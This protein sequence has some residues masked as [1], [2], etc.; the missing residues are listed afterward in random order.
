MQTLK[1]TVIQQLI[2]AGIN[3]PVVTACIHD[4]Y[5][6]YQC[7]SMINEP[8]DQI[9][10]FAEKH[11]FEVAGRGYLNSRISVNDITSFLNL[12]ASTSKLG[13]EPVFANKNLVIDFSSPNIAKP[14]HAGH[15]RSTFIG[16][17][18]AR[19]AKEV[20]YNVHCVNHLGDCGAQFGKLLLG[21]EKTDLSLLSLESMADAYKSVTAQIA[22]ENLTGE[23]YTNIAARNTLTKLHHGDPVLTNLWQQCQNISLSN[24]KSVYSDLGIHFDEF[25]GESTYLPFLPALVKELE[26]NG[27][28]TISNGAKIVEINNLP[29]CLIQKQDGAFLYATTDLA[30]LKHRIDNGADEIWYVVGEPQ[31]LHLK[32][33]FAVSAVSNIAKHIDFGSILGTDGKIMKSRSGD[34]VLLQDILDQAIAE[35]LLIINSKSS[36]GK[37]SGNKD[38]VAK[39]IGYGAIKFF[40]LSQNRSSNYKF[41][42]KIALSLKSGS[43]YIQ[44]ACCRIQSILN[45]KAVFS[46]ILPEET[47]E[48][49]KL[50]LLLA[51]FPE[52]IEDVT[53]DHRIHFLPEY[54]KKTAA[55]FHAFYH[56]HTISGKFN[57]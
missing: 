38:F 53:Q 55:A 45:G 7:E 20:G 21:L 51:R 39:Q 42:L 26:E 37:M 41:D 35:A 52:V 46:D 50:S 44:N 17:S 28:V 13:V 47:P 24:L 54:L 31:T 36:S 3:N 29:P 9:I 18:L 10:A 43:P 30:A 11:G 25:K 34:N 1:N 56:L 19:I 23:N 32:Q 5:G 2:A 49:K 33:I 12:M 22:A 48:F 16:D 8:R 4:S 27:L 40:E 14:L 15:I 6:D 57:S